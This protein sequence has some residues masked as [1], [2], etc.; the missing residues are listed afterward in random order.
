MIRRNWNK[1]FVTGGTSFVGLRVVAALLDAGAD[2]TVLIQ[3]EHEDKLGALRRQVR[4]V[5][6]DIWNSASLKGRSRGHG[7]VIHLVGSVRAQPERGLT[8]HQINLVSARNAI[9]MAVSDGVP[10]FVLLSTVARPPGVSAEYVRSKREAEEYLAGSGLRAAIVRAPLL[11]ERSQTG[12]ALFNVLSTVGSLPLLRVFFGRRAPLPVDVAARGI[13]HAA[14]QPSVPRS[15][16]LYAGE[17]RRLGR[18]PNDSHSGSKPPRSRRQPPTLPVEQDE[19]LPFG[20]LPPAPTDR[21]E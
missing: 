11:F 13:A 21:D 9:A 8:F 12:G 4:L 1:I 18:E 14:L 10:Y 6:G 3:P 15:R 16:M 20:W 17:L 7:A 2:V 5:H 19:E